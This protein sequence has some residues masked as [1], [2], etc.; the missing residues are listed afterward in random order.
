MRVLVTN[1]DGVGSPGLGALAAAVAGRGYDVIVVAPAEEDMS[2]TGASLGRLHADA[3]IDAVPVR[4]PGAEDLPAFS[5]PGPPGL[6]V[7]A[8][9]L[10]AL[11]C[12]RAP[13][14]QR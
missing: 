6:C 1:D 8:A 9:R 3:H 4:L 10:G 13:S 12:T 11:S 2:G 14:A 5:L 7:I